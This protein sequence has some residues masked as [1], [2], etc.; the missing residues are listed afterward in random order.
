MEKLVKNIAGYFDE[1]SKSSGKIG[2]SSGAGQINAGNPMGAGGAAT[3][4]GAAGPFTGA[5]LTAQN[6][7]SF[8][9]SQG[10]RNF[11]ALKTIAL[12]MGKGAVDF[13]AFLPTSI[14][15]LQT[16]QIGER[17][18]FFSNNMNSPTGNPLS[19]KNNQPMYQYGIMNA[20]SAMGT[21][22]SPN[23]ILQA[24]NAG[25][26]AGLTP[27]LKNYN[28]GAGF[29]GVLGGAAL[30]SNLTPGIGIT[31]GMGVMAGIN[32]AQSVNMLKVLGIQVRN[33]SG[34]GMNDLPQIIEQL[35]N[36]LARGKD[37]ITPEDIAVSLMPGNA[38]DSLLTQYFGND[39]TTRS[40][41][42]SGLMQRVKSKVSL[43]ISG[44]KKALGLTG[45][46]TTM[47]SSASS[48]NL[49]EQQ[50]IQSY[51][52]TTNKAAI[53]TTNILQGLYGGLAAAGQRKDIFGDTARGIQNISTALTTFGGARGGAGSA[54][55]SDLADGGAAGVGKLSKLF[56]KFGTAGRLGLG[57]LGV[58]AVGVSAY[59]TNAMYNSDT[60]GDIAP[61]AGTEGAVGS[62][63]STTG[64]QFTGAITINVSAPPGSDPYAFS[65]AFL[66]ALK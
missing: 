7:T 19:A 35:Y 33:N 26:G 24:A 60:V 44:T 54:V 64:P 45:A 46:S 17:M 1:S 58:A 42:V 21:V 51:T 13:A 8:S 66:D 30:A 14:E 36:V 10:A 4:A 62:A 11:S 40:A 57:A 55:I 47:V 37:D 50:L 2:G 22:T 15:T 31:G 43:R 38:L 9:G 65:S 59:K 28:A 56:G 18:R 49:A 20:A 6:N 29:A 27:G 12:A 34:T 32:Q 48:R 23:D 61:L 53:G 52:E 25:I 5:G 63:K 41:V 16:Q 39:P 3:G